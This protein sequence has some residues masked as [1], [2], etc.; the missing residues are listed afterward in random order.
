M[1]LEESLKVPKEESSPIDAIVVPDAISSLHGKKS[2]PEA[3][4]A[5]NTS[6][7]LPDVATSLPTPINPAKAEAVTSI[8]SP[9]VV[10]SLPSTSMSTQGIKLEAVV[11]TETAPASPPAPTNT[12]TSAREIKLEAAIKT[13]TASTPVPVPAN[14]STDQAEEASIPTEL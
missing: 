9:D 1:L 5:A 6:T 11:K 13:E 14:P 7:A 2:T 12:S 10:S 3:E 4:A 8:A